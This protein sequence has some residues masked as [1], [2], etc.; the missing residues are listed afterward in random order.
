MQWNP[1]ITLTVSDNLKVLTRFTSMSRNLGFSDETTRTKLSN[2]RHIGTLRPHRP[3]GNGNEDVN[4]LDNARSVTQIFMTLSR[5]H[6][7]AIDR[8]RS[9]ITL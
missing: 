5:A 1:Y 4:Y 3:P 9:L 8:V 7:F 6:P 2:T